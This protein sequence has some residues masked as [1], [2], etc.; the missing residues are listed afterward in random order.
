MISFRLPREPRSQECRCW[1]SR[2]AR[3]SVLFNTCVWM[4]PS[5]IE[6]PQNALPFAG[7]R[8]ISRS[9]EA[10]PQRSP[11]MFRLIL[12]LL[13]ATMGPRVRL[14][15]VFLPFLG[16]ALA[17]GARAQ[18]LSRLRCTSSPTEAT[19]KA[20]SEARSCNPAPQFPQATLPTVK[21]I[22][23]VS[24]PQQGVLVPQT[25]CSASER[26]TSTRSR[27][28]LTQLLIFSRTR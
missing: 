14:T 24:S 20:Y 8:S 3:P 26:S 10:T 27:Q 12:Y 19:P 5:D 4:G 18:G 13:C 28:P 6:I 2:P 15:D 1:Q 17:G 23:M 7:C 21:P 22:T 9:S 25:R 16:S 11:C